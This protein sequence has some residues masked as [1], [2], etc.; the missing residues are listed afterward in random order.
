VNHSKGR[1][2]RLTP[3]EWLALSERDKRNILRS[4]II[5]PRL[6]MNGFGMIEV[7]FRWGTRLIGNGRSRAT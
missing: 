6:G 3:R 1:I 5:P 4:R 7:E 2:Q